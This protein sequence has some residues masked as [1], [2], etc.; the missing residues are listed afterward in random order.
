MSSKNVLSGQC[1]TT[2]WA[3]SSTVSDR[4]G[5]RERPK[6]TVMSSDGTTIWWAQRRSVDDVSVPS[7]TPAAI[8]FHLW[9][10]ADSN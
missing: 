10:M 7:R 2:V 4:V 5:Y 8:W 3:E 9:I 6:A 1:H